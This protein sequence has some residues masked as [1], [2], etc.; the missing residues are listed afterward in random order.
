MVTTSTLIKL[1]LS[2]R[3]EGDGMK[4]TSTAR[5]VWLH[6][7]Q[8]HSLK[9]TSI[10]FTTPT[11]MCPHNDAFRALSEPEVGFSGGMGVLGT[12]SR[13][14]PLVDMI[15]PP[16]QP[17]AQAMYPTLRFLDLVPAYEHQH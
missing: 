9:S 14:F 12:S 7:A 2:A 11:Q 4:L 10:N 3:A 17:R 6:L 8:E 13:L 5:S 16:V 1:V 15:H